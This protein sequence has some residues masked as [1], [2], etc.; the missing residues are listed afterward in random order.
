MY[1]RAMY[2]PAHSIMLEVSWS[3]VSV[4]SMY[5]HSFRPLS[6]SMQVLSKY[7][8]VYMVWCYSMVRA[9]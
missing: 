6:E 3:V 4:C 5:A 9:V 8:V 2:A 7:S 1:G